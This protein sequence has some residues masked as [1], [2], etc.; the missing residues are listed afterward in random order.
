MVRAD[1]PNQICLIICFLF[2]L[3]QKLSHLSEENVMLKLQANCRYQRRE[4]ASSFP[5]VAFLTFLTAP[6]RFNSTFLI[7]G[8]DQGT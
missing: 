4:A 5:N 7:P 8:S 1:P 2:S 6:C 3:K